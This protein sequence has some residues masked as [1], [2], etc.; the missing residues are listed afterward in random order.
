MSPPN[1][2]GF[3]LEYYKFISIPEIRMRKFFERNV[4][5]DCL[6]IN[7]FHLIGIIRV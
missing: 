4:N 7:H 5:L 1:S 2:W 6:E 3:E